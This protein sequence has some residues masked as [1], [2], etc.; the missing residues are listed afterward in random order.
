MA[1]LLLLGG[2]VPRGAQRSGTTTLMLQVSPEARLEPQQIA[3]NFRVSG[4]GASDVTSQTNNV[5]AM[6][7]AL[8]GQNIRV[9]ARLVS[10]SGPSGAVPAGQLT[11][12]GSR[13]RA[14][15]GGQSAGCSSGVFESGA[16]HDLVSG[17]Q[18]SGTLACALTFALQDPRGLTPGLYAGT[19]QL[20]LDAR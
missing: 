7:R 3:L 14:A 5:S 20:G 6:V 17:W 10:L 19:V 1:A 18:R 11:W 12:S 9:T 4:D 8:P 15:A 2:G 16:A 13:A